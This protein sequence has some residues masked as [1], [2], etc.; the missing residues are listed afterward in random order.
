M[1]LHLNF[2]DIIDILLVY[3]YQLP[4][5]GK[6]FFY[7]F[8]FYIKIKILFIENIQ[9]IS[10]I[11]L[12]NHMTNISIFS[13]IIGKLYHRK[14]PYPI[15][16]FEVEKDPKTSLNYAILFLGLAVYL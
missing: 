1:S 13:I 10:I 16:L 9:I 14:K 3:N 5:L 12:E 7:N 8:Q 2:L 6:K 11:K 4:K 15:I